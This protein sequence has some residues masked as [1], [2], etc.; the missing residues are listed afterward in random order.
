MGPKWPISPNKN[1]FRKHVNEPYFF[2]SCLSTCQKSKSDMNLFVKYWQLILKSHWPTAILSITWK[3]DFSQ[4]CTFCRMLTNH[5]NF[6]FMQI[7]DKNNDVIF[8]KSPKTMF[9]DHSWPFLVIFVRWGFFQKNPALLHTTIYGPLTPCLASEKTNKPIQRKLTDRWKD[10]QTKGQM[11]RPYFIG[12][13]WSRLGVQKCVYYKIFFFPNFSQGIFYTA[14]IFLY[15]LKI[16]ILFIL[17]LKS[18]KPAALN[19]FCQD[20]C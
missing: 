16:L 6:H 1:F 2:H 18:K 5:K 20:F 4:A 9:L 15:W 12:P 10:G 3:P 19:F 14:Q 13:F 17:L 8:L 11:N 7:P